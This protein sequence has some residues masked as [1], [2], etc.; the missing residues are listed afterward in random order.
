MKQVLKCWNWLNKLLEQSCLLQ[1]ILGCIFCFFLIW[2]SYQSNT[3][4][5]KDI[6]SLRFKIAEIG[7]TREGRHA[8]IWTIKS[9]DFKQIFLIPFAENDNRMNLY[10]NGKKIKIGDSVEISI[11]KNAL[12]SNTNNK[13]GALSFTIFNPTNDYLEQRSLWN[14]DHGNKSTMFSN[15]IERVIGCVG[16]F[17]ILVLVWRF[18]KVPDVFNK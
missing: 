17:I 4:E 13:I 9:N 7:H 16:I 11:K 15:F 14:I 18:W 1:A 8:W 6:E 3:I 10:I 12:N 5:E 2:Q